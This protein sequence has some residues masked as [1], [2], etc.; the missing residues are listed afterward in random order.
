MSEGPDQELKDLEQALSKLVPRPP[1]LNRDRLLF[2]AGQARTRRWARLFFSANLVLAGLCLYL[3]YLLWKEP[4]APE[5]RYITVKVVEPAPRE[6]EDVVPADEE[7]NRPP[8]FPWPGEGPPST[9]PS[10]YGTI[11]KKIPSMGE[12][13]LPPLVTS[14]GLAAPGLKPV[15]AGDRPGLLDPALVPFHWR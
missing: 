2:A 3:G 15:R 4:S 14:P 11:Q 6:S 9:Y 7:G 8:P 5:V 12:S 10:G 1:E 13:A